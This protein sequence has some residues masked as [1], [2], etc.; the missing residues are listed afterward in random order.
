MWSAGL[1]L[2]ALLG[3]LWHLGGCWGTRP[4]VNKSLPVRDARRLS[5]SGCPS[6]VSLSLQWQSPRGRIAAVGR[7]AEILSTPFAA[8]AIK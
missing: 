6:F 7:A 4:Y 1:L 2:P 8:E 3:Q 5:P